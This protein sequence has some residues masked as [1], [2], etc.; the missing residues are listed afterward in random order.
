MMAA[1]PNSLDD[2]TKMWSMTLV[3][4]LPHLTLCYWAP[5]QIVTLPAER[6]T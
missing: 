6:P 3:Y 1:N 4:G 5:S 2:M